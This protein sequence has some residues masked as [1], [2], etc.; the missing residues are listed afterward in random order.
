M[1]KI[2][3]LLALAACCAA[4]TWSCSDDKYDDTEIRQEIENLKQE[5]ASMKEQVNS[6]KTIIDALNENKFITNYT[7]AADGS[8][9]I[10]FNDGKAITL[11]NGKDG[12]AAPVIGIAQFEGVY[13]W[14]AMTSGCSTT[15][16]T[17]F[18]LRAKTVKPRP[19]TRTAI[20]RSTAK[21]SKA[22]TDSRSKRS[23]RT[24]QTETKVKT[25][26]LSSKASYRTLTT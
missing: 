10:T 22:K 12:A 13:Y 6:L 14:T 7:E 2:F 15:T 24:A 26:T 21:P 9:T 25:A 23:A 16:R 1:K 11:H 5:I 19:S 3:T 17:R 4:M 8:C 20:G 18:R